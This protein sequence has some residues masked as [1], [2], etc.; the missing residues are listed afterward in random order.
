M[1]HLLSN[2]CRR[3]T[4][5]VL[6]GGLTFSGAALAFGETAPLPG[7][8]AFASNP[9]VLP[10]ALA[11]ATNSPAIR[12]LFKGQELQFNDVQPV[13]KDGSTLVPFRKLF[14]TLGFSVSWLD[15]GTVQ[16]AVGTKDGL[17][18]QLAINSST[19]AVN[20]K[21][22][23]LEVPAQMIDGH[24]MVPL[25]FVAENS[26]YQVTYD[27]A[28]Q[29]ATI[30]IEEGGA[31][32]APVPAQP[33]N[34]ETVEPYV[35]KGYVRDAAGKPVSGVS[36]YADNTLLYDSNILG[37]TDDSGYYRLELPSIATTWRMS[38]EYV[39]EA[40]GRAYDFDIIPDV[41]RPFAGNTGAIRNFTWK[42]DVGYMFFY[43]DHWSFED[44]LP[45]FKMTDLEVTLEPVGP[46]IDGSAGQ[47][48]VKRV[49]EMEY[50][51]LGVDKVPLGRYKA[52]VKWIPSGSQPIPMLVKIEGE[53]EFAESVEFDFSKRRGTL[54]D[55]YMMELEVSY[56]SN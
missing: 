8:A 16:Q 52:T 43:P 6:A 41:D 7:A 30:R 1:N 5:I 4:S 25:R 14:E 49:G 33:Q 34:Q 48:I 2:A 15:T 12:V 27:R 23:P 36:I 18:I 17:T 9:S 47:K 11:L 46:M 38:G 39:L 29:V 56:P 42:N 19:A 45:E 31:G 26:G 51:G 32:S 55:D 21:K 53:G 20:E 28:N 44:D 54:S 13:L 10:S 40:D 3:V 24:T 35:V 22:V 50:E 37:V